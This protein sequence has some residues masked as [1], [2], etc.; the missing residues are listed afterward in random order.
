MDRLTEPLREVLIL[1]RFEELSFK[2]VGERLDRSPEAARKLF[3]R[4]MGALTFEMRDL[5]AP[6][7][8]A[9]DGIGLSSKK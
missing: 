9:G 3:A 2:E 6:G 4:A 1:R 5:R 8:D 7:T